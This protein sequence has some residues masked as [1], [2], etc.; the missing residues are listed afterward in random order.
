M[1]CGIQKKY[2]YELYG[3]SIENI[4]LLMSWIKHIP[5]IFTHYTVKTTTM[6]YT[7]VY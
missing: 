6:Y 5:Y 4:K 3:A 2:K 1:K 7:F